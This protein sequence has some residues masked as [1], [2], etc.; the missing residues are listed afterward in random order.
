MKNLMETSIQQKKMQI[1]IKPRFSIE[2]SH[3]DFIENAEK[4]VEILEEPLANQCSILNYK[5]SNSIMKKY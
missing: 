3:V 2:I 1:F 5:M 4:V